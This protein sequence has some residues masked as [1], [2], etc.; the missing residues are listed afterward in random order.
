M[1][2]NVRIVIGLCVLSAAFNEI[3]ESVSNMNNCFT[4]NQNV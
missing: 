4:K 3:G 2:D 1:I